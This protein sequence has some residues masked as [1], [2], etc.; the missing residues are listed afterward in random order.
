MGRFVPQAFRDRWVEPARLLLAAPYLL[1]LLQPS[2]GLACLLAGVASVG[3]SASLPLQERLMTW[4]AADIRGQVLGL[5]SVG[6]SSMQG[7]G[8]VLAGGLA[9]LLGGGSRAAGLGIGLAATASFL[10]TVSLI[11]SLRRSRQGRRVVMVGPS[12]DTEKPSEHI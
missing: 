5:Y 8:A 6:M 11:P 3:Y 7:V 12:R 10:V 2:L 1:F 9:S 4:T